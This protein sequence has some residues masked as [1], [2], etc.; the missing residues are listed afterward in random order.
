MKTKEYSSDV[1]PEGMNHQLFKRYKSL[2]L[3]GIVLPFVITYKDIS[4]RQKDRL[5]KYSKKIYRKW[6]KQM[7][8][9]ELNNLTEC[10][11]E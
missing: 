8:I 10:K 11:E 6:N 5:K 1:I 7:V 3:N 2:Y 9:D 4:K